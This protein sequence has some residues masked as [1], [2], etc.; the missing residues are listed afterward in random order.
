[1]EQQKILW[2]IFSVALFILVIVGVGVIWFL[3]SNHATVAQTTTTQTDNKAK[4]SFDPY[5]WAQSQNNNYPGLE[6]SP[7]AQ[8]SSQGQNGGNFTIIY[9][10]QP[11]GRPSSPPI[12]SR[13][14][15]CANGPAGALP[16]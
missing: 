8:S 9:E 1:M 15:N 11:G 10:Q 6:S 16:A 14:G 7:N 4:I 5:E 2:I 12:A 3:P 13:L